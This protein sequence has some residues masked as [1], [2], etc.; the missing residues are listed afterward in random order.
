M[1]E[2]G[3]TGSHLL[4]NLTSRAWQHIVSFQTLLLGLVTKFFFRV[5]P[6]EAGAGERVYVSPVSNK[7]RE[8]LQRGE[9]YCDVSQREARVS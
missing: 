8:G 9:R 1:K 3:W 6:G 7:V 5:P 4:I 2:S